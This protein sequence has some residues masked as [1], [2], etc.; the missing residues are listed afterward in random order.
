VIHRLLGTGNTTAHKWESAHR[1]TEAGHPLEAIYEGTNLFKPQSIHFISFPLELW[2]QN[3][4]FFSGPLADKAH[5]AR[6]T[7]AAETHGSS[8]LG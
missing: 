7:N 1:L 6:Q 5:L 3:V 4:C 8:F 2:G